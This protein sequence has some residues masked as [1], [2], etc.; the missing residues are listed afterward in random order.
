MFLNYN[1]KV[2][3]RERWG[4]IPFAKRDNIIVQKVYGI[5][6]QGGSSSGNL[7]TD[8]GEL[9]EGGVVLI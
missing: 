7:D 2:F 6:G 9:K 3:I 1:S 5:F 8:A 4:L